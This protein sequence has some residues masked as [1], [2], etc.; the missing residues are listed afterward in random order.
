L[1]INPV[2]DFS[3]GSLGQLSGG[4]SGRWKE[5]QRKQQEQDEGFLSFHARILSLTYQKT[6]LGWTSAPGSS[7]TLE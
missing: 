7:T 6:V 3:G 1:E 4:R 2:E 5:R